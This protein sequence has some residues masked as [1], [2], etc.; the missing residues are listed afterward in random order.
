MILMLVKGES[1]L[2]QELA[3]HLAPY[4]IS[5]VHYKHP[6]KALDNLDETLP[7]IVLYDVQDFPRHWKILVKYLRD[8]FPKDEVVFL[9]FSEVR[10][11]LEEANKALYL[12]VNGILQY[13][14]DPA[15]L[16]RNIRE[17]FLRYGTFDVAADHRSVHTEGSPLAF[18]FRHPRRKH[19]VTGVLVRLEEKQATFKPDF[20]HE[21]ADL[22]E[23]EELPG[24]S[25]RLG[26]TLLTLDAR[27]TRNSGQVSLS[28]RPAGPQDA[29]VLL[30]NLTAL[31]V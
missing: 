17:V 3:R 19:L 28:I 24:C 11:P 30:E 10:P 25:L 14:G 18:L 29:A 5:V 8:E 22:S 13:N 4:G 1:P 12:G 21:I 6:I 26:E 2:S 16:A 20:A 31:P 27:I 15:T 7:R 23:G 9:L